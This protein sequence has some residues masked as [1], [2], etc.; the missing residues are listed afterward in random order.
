MGPLVVSSVV[1]EAGDR[2]PGADWWELL[3]KSVGRR[4]RG[5][6]GRLLVADSK[7]VYSRSKGIG[8]LQRTV[9]AALKVLGIEPDNLYEL[10]RGL[11]G[12]C[13]G[14]LGDYPWYRDAKGY[15][16]GGDG[17]DVGIAAGVLAENLAANGMRLKGVRSCCL[18]VAE[19][20]RQI[21]AVRNKSRVLFTATCGLIE[22]AMASNVA[23]QQLDIIVDRQGGRARYRSSL[24]RMLAPT[25]LAVLRED[26]RCSSY[27]LRSQASQLRIHFV[28][29]A[30]AQFLPVSLASMVSK[31][32]RELMVDCIN[33]YF[34]SFRAQLKPTAGYWTDGLRFIREVKRAIP[35]ADFEMHQ[36]Q[37]VR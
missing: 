22:A 8:H 4:R 15:R 20:N 19:Y 6:A 1:F 14:R 27:R 3:K 23:E 32:V 9:L 18:D 10:L 12:N 16:L 37:R 29:G 17:A 30:D 21:S 25:E 33:R 34:R 7:K 28:V 5:L 2:Q 11:D 13:L 24:Q 35:E 26:G 31:Y 36:L